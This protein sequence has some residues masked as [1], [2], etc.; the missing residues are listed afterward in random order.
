MNIHIL[1]IAH[2]KKR[3][4]GKLVIE[5]KNEILNTTDTALDDKKVTC[6]KNNCLIHK[7]PVTCL[8]LYACYY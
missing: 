8:L 7:I 2:A 5:Y 3:L 6:K 1:K 4:T